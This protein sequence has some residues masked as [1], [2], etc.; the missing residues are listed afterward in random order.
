MSDQIPYILW[1]PLGGLVSVA[2]AA[3]AFVIT[4]KRHRRARRPK[5][6]TARR[7][8]VLS[9]VKPLTARKDTSLASEDIIAAL[10]EEL[11][12]FQAS[13]RADLAQMRVE[14]RGKDA[15]N[16]P[17]IPRDA[18]DRLEQA[19]DLARVGYDAAA[20]SGTCDLDL[21]DAAAL[22]RFHGPSRVAAQSTQH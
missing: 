5:D 13:Y 3:V 22:V 7:M 1:L 11:A 10:R 14:L 9:A 18:Q 19:I 6:Q 15:P 4:R 2:I 17:S 8:A 12:A 16:H 20:I 21:A